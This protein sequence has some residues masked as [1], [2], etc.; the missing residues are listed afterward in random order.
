MDHDRGSPFCLDTIL[1]IT[2]MS[3]QNSKNESASEPLSH[4]RSIDGS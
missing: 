3:D 1:L 4:H 2:R